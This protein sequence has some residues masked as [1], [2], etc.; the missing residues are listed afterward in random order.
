MPLSF[1]S[2]PSVG[3]TSTQNGRQYVY[4][5]NNVWELASGSGGED[6]LLRSLFVPPAPTS[7]SATA[8]N[9]QATVS[10]TAPS[11][12][13][14]QAPITDYTVQYSS[15]SGS[16]WTTFTRTASTATSAVISSLANGTAYQFRVA[17][18]NAIGTGSY[19]AA[20]AAVTAGVPTDQYFSNVSLLLHA[21][22]SGSAFVDSSPTPKTIT[23]NGDATQSAAQSKWGGKSAYFDGSGDYLTLDANSAF[24]LGTGDMTIEYWWYP[25][26]NAGNETVIDTRPSDSAA[27]LVLGKSGAGAVRCYDGSVVRTGGTMNLNQWNHVAWSRS[28]SDNNI[29][30]NGTRVIQFTSAWDGGPDRGLTIGSNV[31][32]SAENVAGYVDDIRITKGV[33]RYAGDAI[34]VPTAAFPDAGPISAPTSLTATGGDAQVSL[35]WTAPNYNGGS[36]ITDYSVQFSSNSGS[37]WSTFARTAS[38][39]AS[40]TV[41]GLTNGTAY[42]FRVAGINANGTGSYSAA[43]SAVTPSAG[44]PP[45]A[46]TGLTATAGNAQISLAWTAPSSV[47]SSAITGYSV[48][49]TPSGGSAVTVNTGGTATSYTLTGLTNGTAYT[50][51]V[52]AVNAAGT[53]TYTAASSSVTPSAASVPGA[54]RS[55]TV[56]PCGCGNA[57]IS[58]LAPISDGGSAVTTYRLRT[59]LN[60]YATFRAVAAPSLSTGCLNGSNVISGVNFNNPSWVLR[61]YAVNAIG[62]S[63]S[64]AEFTENNGSGNSFGGDCG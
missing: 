46:P 36:A 26:R 56:T 59:S 35:A 8:G 58:W 32:K 42:V 15:N 17:A 18:V 19:S 39:T 2:N 6:T 7:V 11:G 53:G 20:S 54:P 51:R 10:W 45:G 52:A 13:I 30:L 25:T 16:T 43:S 38:T 48:E 29:Y 49:Y 3:A 14:S 5:G 1:P 23:A 60:S 63:S 12:V 34:T 57:T 33:A 40:Q 50:A 62:E 22:G 28:G 64:Y 55:I 44:T 31:L 27:A 4:R 24:G 61:I 41:T 37:T 9:A 21:D 47:G